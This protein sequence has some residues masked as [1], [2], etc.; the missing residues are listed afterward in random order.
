M[1]KTL[2]L[3]LHLQDIW[4]SD[5]NISTKLPLS[6]DARQHW[7]ACNSIG[8]IKNQGSCKSGWVIKQIYV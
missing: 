8:D 4:Y 2:N 7:P 1:I 6:F 3:M 5:N